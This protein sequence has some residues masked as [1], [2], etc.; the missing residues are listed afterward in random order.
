MLSAA[1][2]FPAFC[3]HIVSQL[4]VLASSSSDFSFS[5]TI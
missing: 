3:P 2:E 4:K 1:A 5:L